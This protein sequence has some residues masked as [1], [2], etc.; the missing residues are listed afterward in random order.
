MSL[1]YSG[2]FLMQAEVDT[3]DVSRVLMGI[4]PIGVS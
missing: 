4:H 3:Y 2:N 1:V